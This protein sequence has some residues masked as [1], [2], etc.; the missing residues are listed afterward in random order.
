[1]ATIAVLPEDAGEIIRRLSAVNDERNMVE[2][3][4]PEIA[5]RSGTELLPQGIVL[6][7][8]LAAYNFGKQYP[9][10]ASAI[11]RGF[12]P[13]WIDALIDD[14][15][16]A[17]EAK[18]WLEDMENE[19]VA[20]QKAKTPPR[21]EPKGPVENYDLYVAARRVADIL[22]EEINRAK[23]AGARLNATIK[24][25]G[26]GA[27]PFYSQTESGLF[28]EYYYRSPSQVWTPWGYW[29]F[30]WDV[31]YSGD[32]WPKILDRVLSRLGATMYSP[33]RNESYGTVG[34]VYAIHKVDKMQLPEPKVRERQNYLDREV[35]KKAWHKMSL[36]YRFDLPRRLLK[37]Y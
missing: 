21:V 13:L 20:I 14:K 16:V 30:V 17:D 10:P 26:G 37:L 28:L 4:Y 6:M 15:K 12:V 35:A 19:A 23:K 9:P 29:K 24:G 1:M 18:K 2:K 33:E 27:N 34:P 5:R 25:D 3:L 7:F 8:E 36:R 22:T 31:S 32:P 11:V